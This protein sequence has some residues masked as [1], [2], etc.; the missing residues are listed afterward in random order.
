M[1]RYRGTV[2]SA[3]S[4]EDTFDYLARF[5]SAA[6]WDPGVRGAERLDDGPV[7]PGSIFRLQ[8]KVGPLVVPL[9]YRIVSYRRPERVVV[10]GES[11]SIRSE[12][13]ITVEP[14]PGGGSL[15]TYDADLRLKGVAALANPVL[16]P[17][18]DR[19]GDRALDGLRGVLSGR[20]EP[21]PAGPAAGPEAEGTV[22]RVVDE[23]LEATVVGSFSAI[24]PAVRSRLAGWRPPPPMNGRVVLVT[25]ATS[26][27]G[28]AAAVGLAR[29]GATVRFVAR[30]Q[31]RAARAVDTITRAV[32]GADVAYLLA[33]MGELD[34]VRSVAAE[35][36]AGHDRLDVLIHNAGAL[37]RHHSLTGGGLETTVATQ[38]VAP[39]LLTGLLLPR[40]E[41]AAPARVIQVSSGGM[42][43]Q[44]FDLATL[45]MSEADYDGTVAY[46]RVKR[47]QLV[48]MHEWA[49]RV[50]GAQ[51]AFQA[52]HPGWAD[53]PGIR[54][55]LP[56]FSRLMGPLLRSPEQ[57]ADTLVWLA[58]A[59]EG[60]ATDARFWLDR[61]PRWEHKVP[62]TRPGPDGGRD[63]AE[64]WAWCEQRAGWSGPPPPG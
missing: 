61:R 20:T 47:A 25:G 38:L 16:G 39:F 42:Y 13:T 46:A 27:L 37:S 19:I 12:D 35:F 6:E 52:M 17:A 15:L 55:G 33:D 56:G 23:L 32:P 48:L 59:P 3:R 28:E 5:S 64:L 9:D 54:S 50:D 18:F 8:V 30:N 21:E 26:G 40:L 29:L 2:R 7:G 53:T 11:G 43:T 36:A 41:A 45:E 22:A 31:E 57:G 44:R 10:L 51:V 4:A 49:R 24:G 60:V 14:D 1:A 34:Q 62:W 63:G 58:A